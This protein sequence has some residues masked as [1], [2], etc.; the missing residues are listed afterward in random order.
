MKLSIMVAAYNQEELIKRCLNSIPVRDDI[1]VVI[2]D[3]FS[4][5]STLDSIQSFIEQ[6]DLKVNLILHTENLGGAEAYNTCMDNC[7]GEYIYQIDNDDYLLTGNFERA[8]DE[9]D[10]TDIV[11]IKAQSNDGTVLETGDD[12]H[13]LCAGWFKF[14]RREYLGN[15]RRPNNSHG[16]DYEMNLEL[17]KKPHT[18]KKLDLI[19][20]HYNYPREG[21]MIW[22]LTHGN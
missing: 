17:I 21:S 22:N 1:E 7:T 8:M 11:Y 4:T 16:G 13:N 5:D 19:C 9:L 12:N 15:I 18:S 2:V 14:I 3:D 20:Y 6:T 10:G